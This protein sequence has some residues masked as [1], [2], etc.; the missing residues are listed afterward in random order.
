MNVIYNFYYNRDIKVYLMNKPMN[1]E[2]IICR[3][4]MIIIQLKKTFR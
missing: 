4:Y 2:E 1:S 3:K